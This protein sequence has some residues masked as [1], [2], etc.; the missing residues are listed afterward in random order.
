MRVFFTSLI[1]I[2]LL[3]NHSGG[4]TIGVGYS[5]Y[6]KKDIDRGKAEAEA[7]LDAEKNALITFGGYINFSST[8]LTSQSNASEGKNSSVKF[9][10]KY[11]SSIKQLMDGM[12]KT[13]EK[14]RYELKNEGKKRYVVAR[15]KF[16]V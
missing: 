13:I 15:C 7:L 6:F 4:Q 9:D 11:Q 16:S 10:S 1:C 12:V 2:F 3:L 5:G 8:S 14:P